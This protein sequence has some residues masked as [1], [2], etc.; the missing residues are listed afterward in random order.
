V[1][2]PDI[3]SLSATIMRASLLS[4]AQALDTAKAMTNIY[5]YPP[6]EKF[7]TLE[8]LALEA[9]VDIGYTHAQ[10]M[11]AEWREAG[12]LDIFFKL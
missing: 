5:I 2:T 11:I 8:F 10:K 9:I 1:Q 3:P 4:S 6:V 7:G 12:K